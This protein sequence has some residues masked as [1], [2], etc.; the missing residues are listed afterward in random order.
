MERTSPA[1]RLQRSPLVYVL[2]QIVI[3]P[4]LSMQD[5]I[6]A[7]QERL[8][9]KGYIKYK[10]IPTQ[11]IILAPQIQI[12]SINRWFFS[13]KNDEEAVIISPY[14]IVFETTNYDVF[15]TFVQSFKEILLIFQEVTNVSLAE[16]IGLRYVD[17]IRPIEGQ[18]LSDYL[19]PGLLG[20]SAEKFG[21]EKS[22][23]LYRFETNALTSV[24]Q[25][26]LRLSQADNGSYL[27]PDIVLEAVK[28]GIKIEQG[29]IVTVL[30]VDNFSLQQRDF[31]ADDLIESLWQLH[32]YSDRAFKSA[33]TPKA[34]SIWGSENT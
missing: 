26:A 12:T 17:V 13:N 23:S 29:E 4:I 5:Y 20:I 25:I 1:L 16:R 27:P 21:A 3:S 9:N 8:R 24:G 32:D 18:T 28:S 15:D 19:Q 30:D 14:F 34:L 6:P 31:V 11:E 22:K 33:V 10:N 7:I 2:A